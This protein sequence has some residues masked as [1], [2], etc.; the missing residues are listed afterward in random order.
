MVKNVREMMLM[1]NMLRLQR[2][3]SVTPR[4]TV[5]IVGRERAKHDSDDAAHEDWA[6]ANSIAVV[7]ENSDHLYEA[8]LEGAVS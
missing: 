3:W 5:H 1:K 4:G 7:V 2:P 6:D 8:E